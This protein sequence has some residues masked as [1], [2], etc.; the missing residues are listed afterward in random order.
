[1]YKASNRLSP[2]LISD[3]VRLN[4]SHPYNLRHDFQFS[5]PLYKTSFHGTKSIFHLGP[6]IW[7]IIP[8][9]F[10]ELLSFQK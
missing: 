4:N 2:S 8:V 1:M 7:D 6:I 9:T 3:I 5:R 10:K